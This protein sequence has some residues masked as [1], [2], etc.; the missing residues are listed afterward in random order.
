MTG[1]SQATRE[2]VYAR[3]TDENGLMRCERCGSGE[4][5]DVQLHHRRPRQMSGSKRPDTNEASNCLALDGGCHRWVES[6]RA[7][8]YDAGW[9]LRSGQTPAEEP[10]VY[11][12]EWC[13]LTDSGEAIPVMREATG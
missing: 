13:L 8:S 1:F 12:G 9:L 3:A 10:V 11:R 4:Y 5:S 6:Y 7:K 2:L